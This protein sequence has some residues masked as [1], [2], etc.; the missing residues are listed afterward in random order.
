[1]KTVEIYQTKEGRKPFE[2]WIDSLK[3]KQAQIIIATR[4][5]RI[6]AGNLGLYRAI[7]SGVCEL[8][9]N[10][11]PG[12]RVYFGQAGTVMLVLLCGGDKKSQNKDIKMAWSY[13][14]DYLK[15]SQKDE[16]KGV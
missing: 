7:G 3:D 11:G 14:N 12:Y 16:K 10:Y 4:I 5:A 2:E 15:R 9:I 1:M 6:K 8:K 13:W